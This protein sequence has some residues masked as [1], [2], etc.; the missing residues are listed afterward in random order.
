MIRSWRFLGLALATVLGMILVASGLGSTGTAHAN[1][2]GTPV[3]S[4]TNLGNS[5]AVNITATYDSDEAGIDLLVSGNPTT[6]L[7]GAISLVSCTANSLTCVHNPI[8]SSGSN[9][10]WTST[11]AEVKLAD[12]ADTGAQQLVMVFQVTTSSSCGGT[13]FTAA[14]TQGNSTSSQASCAAGTATAT[15][16]ITGTPG[17]S[18]AHADAH[19]HR[20][21]PGLHRHRLG[22]AQQH[23]LQRL[24][25]RHRP[26]ERQPG[27]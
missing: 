3:W 16:T 9:N 8:N 23:Q 14:S 13:V 5:D 21:G 18:H 22:L 6:A 4:H 10:R 19:R 11:D 17:D 27:R 7:N 1:P 20:H 15:P 24:G 25:L 26:G 12:G 2:V